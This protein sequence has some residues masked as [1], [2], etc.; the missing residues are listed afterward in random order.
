M[1]KI[2]MAS[3]FSIL[4]VGGAAAAL[5]EAPA[6]QTNSIGIQ[7]V[8][9]PPGSFT[10]GRELPE[11]PADDPKTAVNEFEECRKKVPRPQ[12]TP[13]HRV[14][15]SKGFWIGQFE[16]TQA[17]WEEVM[18]SNPSRFKSEKQEEREKLP[19]EN[20]LWEDVQE[21]IRLLNEKE[22]KQYRL[23]TEAEWEYVCHAGKDETFCGGNKPEPLA[24]YVDT[25]GM[26]PH[27][28]GTRQANQFGVYD[29]SGNVWEWVND[30]FGKDYY[31]QSPEADP[32]GPSEGKERVI[33]GGAWGYDMSFARAVNRGGGIAVRRCGCVGFRLVD[34]E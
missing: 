6:T 21:F 27:W 3:I 34:P 16:V 13:A 11:C 14:V 24:W 5:A 7:F 18:H 2:V 23:P 33:R 19:V 8:R 22:G 12:E 15:I 1:K 9:V 28:I 10:M 4:A 26:R 30:W 32:Q 17:Q 20:V 25:S 29:M 31:S